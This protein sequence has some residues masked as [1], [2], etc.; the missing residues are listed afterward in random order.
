MTEEFTILGSRE[1]IVGVA[2][3]VF[4]GDYENILARARAMS[5]NHWS[6]V[7]HALAHIGHLLS[8]IALFHLPINF[9]LCIFSQFSSAHIVKLSILKGDE[10]LPFFN[11]VIT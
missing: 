8:S 4:V 9:C 11:R 6:F 3:V 2:T 1:A 7:F 10:F 5:C